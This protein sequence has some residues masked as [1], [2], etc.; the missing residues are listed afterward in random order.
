MVAQFNVPLSTAG[1]TLVN[2]PVEDQFPIDQ[3]SVQFQS[4]GPG[5]DWMYFGGMTNN[6]GQTPLEH[7]LARWSTYAVPP[8]NNQD[9]IRVTGYGIDVG[10]ATNTQQTATGLWTGQTAS[11][12]NFSTYIEVGNSGSP[13]IHEATGMAL[14]ILTH[15]ACTSATLQQNYATRLTIPTLQAAF[16]NPLGV[17]AGTPCNAVG[18]A[19]CPTGPLTSVISATGTSSVSANNLVLHANNIPSNK[20]GLFIYSRNKQSLPFGSSNLCVGGSGF[21]IRRLPA[22]NSGAGTTF[23]F[24]VNQFTLPGGDV[25]HAG[26]VIYFQAWFR[27][28]AGASETSNG[29]EVSIGF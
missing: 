9:V 20:A 26:E 6:L 28:G 10:T 25:F 1:G 22:L 23:T 13:M 3:S 27:T 16:A 11:V 19:Y 12:F 14:G 29:L 17:C 24:A 7:Q 8:F 4:A 18:D 2:P 21:P 5:A 15:T